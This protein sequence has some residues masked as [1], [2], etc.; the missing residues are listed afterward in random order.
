[1]ADETGDG[2]GAPVPSSSPDAEPTPSEPTYTFSW[3]TV[4]PVAT[5]VP[6]AGAPST[7]AA[8]GADGGVADGQPAGEESAEVLPPPRRRRARAVAVAAVVV[9]AL[10]VGGT[11][12]AVS[13]RSPAPSATGTPAP[14]RSP[15]PTPTPSATLVARSLL[16]SLDD[17]LSALVAQV[18]ASDALWTQTD[19][20]VTDPAARD[21][22]RAALDAAS[23]WLTGAWEPRDA[24]H[25][26]DLAAERRTHLETLDALTAAVQ[27]DHDAWAAARSGPVPDDRATPRDARPGAGAPARGPAPGGAGGPTTAPGTDGAAPGASSPGTGDPGTDPGTPSDPGPAPTTPSAP[28]PTAPAPDPGGEGPSPQP[29]PGTGTTPDAGAATP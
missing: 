23:A 24:A 19:G 21:R 5:T 7:A 8:H 28:D 13:G 10:G 26:R 25:A 3:P 29:D 11:A 27:Q 2:T 15:T 9:A 16:T 1:M 17:V 4:A 12:L 22:M 20:Q 18:D 14:D 6:A